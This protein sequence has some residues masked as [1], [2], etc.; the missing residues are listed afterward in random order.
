MRPTTG[1][2][3]RKYQPSNPTPPPQQ[4]HGLQKA[5]RDSHSTSEAA[6]DG[7]SRSWT[8]HA[9]PSR[10]AQTNALYADIVN[11]VTAGDR[12]NSSTVALGIN[13]VRDGR[14]MAIVAEPP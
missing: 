6:A 10:A 8:E 7:T 12:T 2:H 9:Q 1:Y 5:Q 11:H 14:V 3:R 13:Q 4:F